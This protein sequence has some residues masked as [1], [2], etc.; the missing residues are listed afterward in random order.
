MKQYLTTK[1]VRI[2]EGLHDE[3][4]KRDEKVSTVLKKLLEAYAS[5]NLHLSDRRKEKEVATSFTIQP[6]ILEKVEERTKREGVSM[7]KLFV[8]LLSQHAAHH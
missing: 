1:N 2:P 5:G 7:N 3:L 4:K 8:T 6:D